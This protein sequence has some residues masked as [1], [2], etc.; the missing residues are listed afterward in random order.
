MNQLTLSMFLLFSIIL[1][2][3]NIILGLLTGEGRHAIYKANIASKYFIKNKYAVKSLVFEILNDSL[4][5]YFRAILSATIIAL[6]LF[7]ASVYF[8][9]SSYHISHTENNF[10]AYWIIFNV[11]SGIEMIAW[12]TYSILC[13]KGMK[14]ASNWEKL[15]DTF[16]F[17]TPNPVEKTGPDIFKTEHTFVV[18]K[19]TK[20][21]FKHIKWKFTNSN[22]VKDFTGVKIPNPNIL[23]YWTVQDYDNLKIDYSLNITYDQVLAQ[24]DK[25][26]EMIKK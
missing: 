21:L 3:V 18:Y 2:I 20:L 17:Y 22:L 25:L 12:L 9:Y 14:R 5:F 24:Y 6:I 19:P 1:V 10:F 11:V 7:G 26:I 13:K 8:T 23:Y 4:K 16:E 15:N